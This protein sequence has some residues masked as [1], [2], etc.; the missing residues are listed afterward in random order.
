[1]PNQNSRKPVGA[2]QASPS[3]SRPPSAAGFTPAR[4][5]R[6]ENAVPAERR[7]THASPLQTATEDAGRPQTSPLQ[8]YRLTIEYDGSRFSGWQDQKNA[9]TIVGELKAAFKDAGFEP[10]DLG[11]AGRTDAGVH[12]LAQ[13]A[14]LRLKKKSDGVSLANAVNHRLPG[15]IHVLAIDPVPE[16]FHARHDASS[17]TYLY[18]ISKRR[19]AFAKRFVWWVKEPLDVSK[20][21][22]AAAMLAGRHDFRLLSD[23]AEGQ[24]STIVVVEKAEIIEQGALIL[25]RFTASHFLWRMVRRVVGALKKV[26]EGSLSLAEWQGLLAAKAAP[27]ERGT[28]AEWTAP[29]SGLFLEH[30]QYPAGLALAPIR[31]ATPVAAVGS[32]PRMYAP[33]AEGGHEAKGRHDHKTRPGARPRPPHRPPTPMKHFKKPDRRKS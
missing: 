18:Q 33:A 5:P 29:A 30:V 24:T 7:A 26:G 19:T 21:R 14:H 15:G 11:G 23:L 12:A 13:V 31:P 9:K 10:S 2:R 28:P 27:P 8:T 17:R 4:R 22:E 1:M 32:T 16:S 25:F 20:M 6:P 3:S